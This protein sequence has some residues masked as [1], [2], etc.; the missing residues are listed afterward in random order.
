VCVWVWSSENKNPLHLLWTSRQ[1]RERLRN[2]Q[3]RVIREVHPLFSSPKH[4]TPLLMVICMLCNVRK[5]IPWCY[6]PDGVTE[7][8]IRTFSVSTRTFT[9]T[10]MSV[11]SLYAT[12]AA[13]N[14]ASDSGWLW[15]YYSPVTSG[16][17]YPQQLSKPLGQRHNM[18]FHLYQVCGST[19]LMSHLLLHCYLQHAHLSL[20]LWDTIPT[21]VQ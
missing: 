15:I 9:S 13:F 16:L 3:V 18:L 19:L 7:T 21:E 12:I 17:L 8:I 4:T 5:N 2:E 6:F 1:K 10:L 14:T 11:S 20:C